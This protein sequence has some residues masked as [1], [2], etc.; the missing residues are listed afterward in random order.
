MDNVVSSLY[1]AASKVPVIPAEEPAK[2]QPLNELNIN[3]NILFKNITP[4]GNYKNFVAVDVETTG[5]S[6]GRDKIVE[7][8]AVRFENGVPTEIFETLINPE[9]PIPP[10]AQRI[11]GITDDMV[12]DAPTI[13][14]IIP[15]FDAFVGAS[16][17]VGHNLEF[18]LKFIYRSGSR[19]LERQR[20][21]FCTLTQAQKLLEKGE[22]VENHKLA[23]LC[24]YYGIILDGAHRSTSDAI[25]AGMLLEELSNGLKEESLPVDPILAQPKQIIDVPKA[26][27]QTDPKK[28]VAEDDFEIIDPPKGQENRG[29]VCLLLSCILGTAYLA[30]FIAYF[31]GGITSDDVMESIG[32]SIATAL[33]TPHA[34]GLAG[35]VIFGWISY[36]GRR[37]WAALT[38]AIL[39]T[40]SGLLFMVYIVFVAPSAILSFVGFARMPSSPPKLSSRRE[41]IGLDIRIS[42]T[43][44]TICLAFLGGFAYHFIA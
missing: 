2:I 42:M 39:Y 25:A 9:K 5:L 41:R 19:I 21:Y 31:Y 14:R 24:D 12:K 15:A 40:I 13:D 7:I 44:I 4:K 18:D 37:R 27:P 23:T 43:G 26:E 38:S 10:D 17:I 3:F 30:Y 22:D 35:G 1:D 11:N 16:D 8:S 28:V 34:I 36:V 29:G 6:P 32:T 33:V 20:R